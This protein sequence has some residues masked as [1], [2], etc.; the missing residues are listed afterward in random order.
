MYLLLVEYS[1]RCI[2]LFQIIGK[3]NLD[4][5]KWDLD[6]CK[7]FRGEILVMQSDK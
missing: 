2:F 5:C 3:G 1:M 4:F 6:S 7:C